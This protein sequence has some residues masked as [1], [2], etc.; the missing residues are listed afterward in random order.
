MSKMRTKKN[1]IKKN[2]TT[3]I[4]NKIAIT[5]DFESG[6]IVHKS[7]NGNKVILEIKMNRINHPQKINIK[8]GFIL[9]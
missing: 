9:K 6:N 5:S 2:K 4:E 1:K 7:T 3:K 8:I